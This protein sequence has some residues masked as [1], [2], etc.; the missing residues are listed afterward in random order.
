MYQTLGHKLNII[1]SNYHFWKRSEARD[2][3]IFGSLLIGA[4]PSL[5]E[6][7]WD[8]RKTNIKCYILFSASIFVFRQPYEN[9]NIAMVVPRGGGRV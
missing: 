3:T 9:K 4:L 5:N 8:R 7:K 1:V 6:K 2:M